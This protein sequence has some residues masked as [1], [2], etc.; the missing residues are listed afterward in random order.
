MNR[1]DTTTCQGVRCAAWCFRLRLKL[2]MP[3][4][5][6]EITGERS[7]RESEC[8]TAISLIT[9]AIKSGWALQRGMTQ[10][11]NHGRT[12]VCQSAGG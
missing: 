5:E 10:V 2:N 11:M 1:S 6:G 8:P 4:L 7:P 12:H 9:T 3:S